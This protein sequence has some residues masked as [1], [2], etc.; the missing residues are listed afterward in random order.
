[1]IAAA[2]ILRGNVPSDFAQ[3]RI[4]RERAAY[5]GLPNFFSAAFT[6]VDLVRLRTEKGHTLTVVEG[7]TIARNPR[8]RLLYSL[9]AED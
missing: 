6:P 5:S 8:D 9:K 4:Y 7:S 1:V 3:T 2:L